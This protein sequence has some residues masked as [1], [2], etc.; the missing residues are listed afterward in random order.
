MKLPKHVLICGKKF[1]LKQNKAHDGGSF[2]EAT[3]T[4]EIGTLD[5][6]E[7]AENF[8]HEIGEAILAIRD[9]RFVPQKHELENG[10]YRFFLD[11]KDWQTFAKDLAIALR[12]IDFPKTTS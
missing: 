3:L 5:P 12:G 1:T 4:I 10:D 6:D 9:F 2:D 8:L 7:V 11:H